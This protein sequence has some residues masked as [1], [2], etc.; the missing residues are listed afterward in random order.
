[1]TAA[2]FVSV[3][4]YAIDNERTNFSKKRV[5]VNLLYV[6]TSVFVVLPFMAAI[7]YLLIVF[8][9]NELDFAFVKT[10]VGVVEL[11][12]GAA[13]TMFIDSLFGRP[14][15]PQVAPAPEPQPPSPIQHRSD[16]HQV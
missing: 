13:F 16:F 11:F 4:R 6:L 8:Q 1:M 15:A 5:T 7:Y 10:G 2:Y 14:T 12:L 3:V 9:N